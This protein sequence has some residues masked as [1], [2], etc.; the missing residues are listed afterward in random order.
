MEKRRAFF[1]DWSNTVIF[2]Y[3]G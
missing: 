3:C 2:M 1:V